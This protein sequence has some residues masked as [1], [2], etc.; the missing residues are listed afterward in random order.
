M[1]DH[2]RVVLHISPREGAAAFFAKI[3]AAVNVGL[4]FAI[5]GIA[6]YV[7]LKRPELSDEAGILLSI[8]LMWCV[9]APLLARPRPRHATVLLTQESLL[10]AEG[11]TV[12]DWPDVR[13]HLVMGDTLVFEPTEDARRAD[14]VIKPRYTIPLGNS[15]REEVISAFQDRP[16]GSRA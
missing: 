14:P 16:R 8:A 10:I 9:V 5:V 12:L 15:T 2:V 4:R 11:A 3:G 13:T 7:V 1:P 6:S